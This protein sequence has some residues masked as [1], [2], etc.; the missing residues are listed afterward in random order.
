MKFI[1]VRQKNS[2]RVAKWEYSPKNRHRLAAW[3]MVI[4]PAEQVETDES[5]EFWQRGQIP[6]K[7]PEQL[8]AERISALQKLLSASDWYVTRFAET[9]VPVPEAVGK[10]RAEARKEIDALRALEAEQGA[11]DETA[12]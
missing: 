2:A 10:A 11:A 4:V 3:N 1:F 12:D 9:G 7:S 5:G 8:R 6:V